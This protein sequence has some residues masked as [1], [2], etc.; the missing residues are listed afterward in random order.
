MPAPIEVR[1]TA[2]MNDSFGVEGPAGGTHGDVDDVDLSLWTVPKAWDTTSRLDI[3][4][5]PS[6]RLLSPPEELHSEK[7]Q[8]L[9]SS[10][11]SPRPS[12]VRWQFRTFFKIGMMKGTDPGFVL[13]SS[14]HHSKD[15]RWL[16][17]WTDRRVDPRA[18]EEGRSFSL[19]QDRYCTR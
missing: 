5:N 17:Q 9:D 19:P 7:K 14:T 3:I 8:I 6:D 11:E 4:Y 15:F 2:I 18:R 13:S 10:E 1:T 12:L 16:R